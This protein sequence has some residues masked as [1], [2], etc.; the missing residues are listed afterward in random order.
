ML[1]AHSGFRYLVMIAGFIVIGYAVYGMATGRSYDKT[2]R[3]TSAVFTGLVDL[4]ALLGIVTLLS[5]TFY[6]ALIG[7][8]TMMVLAIVVAHVVSVVIKRRPEE[9]R[10]Y[11]PHLVG[12][13]VV[14]G[15]IAAGI[16]AIGRPLVG[17]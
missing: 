3:I 15:L 13:L 4:T 5:G 12:T 8:I 16:M 11:A 9:E 7:H 1:N 14:L 10:T 17:S 6:P 2:M